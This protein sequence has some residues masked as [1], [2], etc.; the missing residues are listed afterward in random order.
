MSTQLITVNEKQIPIVTLSNE[1]YVA[2][3]PICEAIG[4]DYDNQ[5]DKINNDEILKQLT[6]LKGVVAA[7]G[8]TRKM[9]VISLRYVFGW[10]FTIN[11]NKVKPEIKQDVINFKK[12][13]YDALFDTFT[14]RTSILK[15]KTNYQIEIERLE[16][17]WKQTDDY[18]EIEKLKKQQKN[19]T[20]RLNSLDKK[21]VTEQFDLF[22]KE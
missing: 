15:E 1:K 17:N 5:I 2:I 13:C 11:P 16:A 12:E 3:K 18:K 9:R 7:D 14:K 19:A 6:P 4:V 21:I 8:K 22:K 20:Q 10:L